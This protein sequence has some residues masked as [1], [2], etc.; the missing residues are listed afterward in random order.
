MQEHK[1]SF[2]REAGLRSTPQ[3]PEEKIDKNWFDLKFQVSRDI[4]YYNYRS[5]FFEKSDY[6]S[7]LI[8]FV[9]ATT[10]FALILGNNDFS[11]LFA[12]TATI[13][14]GLDLIVGFA[15]Q[16]SEKRKIANKLNEL[17]I[18]IIKSDKNKENLQEL[19]AELETIENPTKKVLNIY[20]HNEEAIAIGCDIKETYIISK[21]RELIMQLPLGDLFFEIKKQN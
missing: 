17:E 11:A 4:R 21:Q 8:S 5:S 20:C 14:T 12:I 1:K 16:A 6:I 19:Q 2:E 9:S 10:A 15:N 18:K 13:F 7:K 3:S